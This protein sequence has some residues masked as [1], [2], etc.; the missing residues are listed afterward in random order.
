MDKRQD[1]NE[2]LDAANTKD[3]KA[4]EASQ[5]EAQNAMPQLVQQK[6]DLITFLKAGG[7]SGITNDFGKQSFFDSKSYNKSEKINNQLGPS[8]KIQNSLSP[9]PDT[10]SPE[11]VNNQIRPSSRSGPSTETQSDAKPVRLSDMRA[12]ARSSEENGDNKAPLARAEKRSDQNVETNE[13]TPKSYMLDRATFQGMKE[14]LDKRKELMNQLKSGAKSGIT[15]DFGKQEIYDSESKQEN[16]KTEGVSVTAGADSRRVLTG[17]LIHN[18][19]SGSTT[20]EPVAGELHLPPGK[21][22]QDN[23]DQSPERAPLKGSVS[24]D[25]PA[26]SFTEPNAGEL[27]LPKHPNNDQ[28]QDHS[29]QVFGKV[30]PKQ[31]ST[32][33]QQQQGKV[34]PEPVA[35]E[36]KPPQSIGTEGSGEIVSKTDQREQATAIKEAEARE[37]NLPPRGS[38]VETKVWGEIVQ[39]HKPEFS[40]AETVAGELHLPARHSSIQTEASRETGTKQYSSTKEARS[41]KLVPTEHTEIKESSIKLEGFVSKNQFDDSNIVNEMAK[42]VLPFV[43]YQQERFNQRQKD[44]LNALETIES[45]PGGKYLMAVIKGFKHV[46][47]DL[48]NLG[49]DGIVLVTRRP[50]EILLSTAMDLFKTVQENPEEAVENCKTVMAS[51]KLAI[52]EAEISDFE[53]LGKAGQRFANK[54]VELE[55]E[56]DNLPPEDKLEATVYVS[57]SF[58]ILKGASKT[59]MAHSALGK[60]E[61]LGISSTEAHN[62][63]ETAE[64]LQAAKETAHITEKLGQRQHNSGRKS[65]H[66]E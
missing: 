48:I 28:E 54:I 57:L 50:E 29:E 42:A 36:W 9:S 51:I 25:Q 17:H 12:A 11:S 19:Q 20:P 58:L 44:I 45:L 21:P 63:V 43:L 65:G 47:D 62:A 5:S 26:A 33:D 52:G 60:L 41:D 38:S 39:T 2:A 53:N 61:K 64:W 35:G 56:F 23:Y 40:A 8:D 10:N 13:R 30:I 32:K 16:L 7:K 55:R 59:K 27:K 22:T 4:V 1:N 3:A 14:L 37:L 6:K 66:S 15:E 31:D 24:Y 46:G 34:I 18:E 49:E